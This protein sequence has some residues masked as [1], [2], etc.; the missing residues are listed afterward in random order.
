MHNI[1]NMI[2][3]LVLVT[4][5]VTAGI[6]C[7]H[8]KH[9][10]TTVRNRAM[11]DF[12]CPKDNLTLRVADVQGARKLAT[13][14]GVYG[15]GKKAVYVYAPDT[16]TWVINGAVSEMPADFDVYE[17]VTKGTDKKR[18]QKKAA[19]AEKQGGMSPA[20]EAPTEAAPVVT[21]EPAA[22]ETPA[23]AAPDPS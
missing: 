19:K 10:T 12:A 7:K 22:P 23:E 2:S 9:A 6:A 8:N 21:P 15:C 14:I 18:D 16:D 11:F 3:R 5:L 4:L 17:N 20:E 13:Q 1:G